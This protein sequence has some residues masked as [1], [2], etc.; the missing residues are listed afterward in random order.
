MYASTGV[1]KEGKCADLDPK[2]S[3]MPPPLLESQGEQDLP[4]P[5]RLANWGAEG[6]QL[7][8]SK[9]WLAPPPKDF[10]WSKNWEFY[11]KN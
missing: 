1:G 7:P 5:G 11:L 10:E 4:S 8:P 2:I 3:Q 6:G 9:T